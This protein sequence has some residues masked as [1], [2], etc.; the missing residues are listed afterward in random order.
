[1]LEWGRL[2]WPEAPPRSLG[3]LAGKLSS[4]LSEQ[5]MAVSR[6]SYGPDAPHWDGQSVARSLRSFA[7]LDD[8]EA[9]ARGEALPPLMPT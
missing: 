2:Q 8:S 7:V 1:M 5:L 3:M 4:P 9:A 6:S